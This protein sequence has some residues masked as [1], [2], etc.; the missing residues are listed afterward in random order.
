M[1]IFMTRCISM[2]MI[3]NGKECIYTVTARL[4]KWFYMKF[5]ARRINMHMS[6]NGREH[7]HISIRLVLHMI[8]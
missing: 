3:L 2:P 5:S 6:L 4:D 1:M 7:M 8:K